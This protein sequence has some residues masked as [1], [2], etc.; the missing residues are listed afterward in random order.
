[1]HCGAVGVRCCLGDAAGDAE[2]EPGGTIHGSGTTD[3]SCS[4]ADSFL[5]HLSFSLI[6]KSET[7]RLVTLTT[8]Y[9]CW[10]LPAILDVDVGT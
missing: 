1:M 5:L 9:R 4:I 6:K 10:D 7:E 3:K 8:E 2:G